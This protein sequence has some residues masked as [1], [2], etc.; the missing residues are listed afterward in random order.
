MPLCFWVRSSFQAVP[1][2]RPSTTFWQP[3]RRNRR[4]LSA[5]G[6]WPISTP[7]QKNYDEAIKVVRSGIEQQPDTLALHMILASVLE[8]KGDYESAISEY[9][10]M[11]ARQ[12]ANLILQIIWPACCWTTV[13]TKPASREPSHWR[14]FFG[15][16][17]YRNS[18]I[19]SAGQ[20]IVRATTGPLSL[21]PRRHLP[22]CPARPR[23]ATTLAW[24]TSQQTSLP[25]HRSSSKRRWSWL[26]TMSW[27]RKSARR[28]KKPDHDPVF[29]EG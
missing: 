9:E 17:R 16:R 21:S 4:I 7:A 26:R 29:L 14:Q 1:P 19:R 2:I 12:P 11:L 10:F 8:R 20:I 27:P 23:F 13:P 15:N 24:D 22:P 3:S 6:R 18:R 28:L 5:I 25:K